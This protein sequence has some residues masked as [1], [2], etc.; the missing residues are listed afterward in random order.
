MRRVSIP[1]KPCAAVMGVP[2]GART[3]SG[4]ENRAL[5]MRLAASTRIV[6]AIGRSATDWG[7]LRAR[8]RLGQA[9]QVP[10]GI[11]ELRDGCVGPRDVAWGHHGLAAE[12]LDLLKRLRRIGYRDVEGFLQP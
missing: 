11:R 6:R 1:R 7:A 5:K 4:V 10:V 8:L 3:E 12:R 9:D 2:S